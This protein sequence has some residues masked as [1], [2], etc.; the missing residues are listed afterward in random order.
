M[1]QGPPGEKQVTYQCATVLS[2]DIGLNHRYLIEVDYISVVSTS[3]VI[4]NLDFEKLMS[5]AIDG[6][7][8]ITKA[9]G[10]HFEVGP[11]IPSS[12]G[13]TDWAKGVLEI[14]YAYGLQLRDK[15]R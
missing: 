10:R 13:P 11:T 6:S 1:N 4:Y 12:G 9:Q 7:E 3:L 8:A 2:Q 14:P 15:E 5:A